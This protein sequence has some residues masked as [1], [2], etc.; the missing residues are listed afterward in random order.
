METLMYTKKDRHDAYIRKRFL[1]FIT[2]KNDTRREGYYEDKQKM[3]P[4]CLCHK[5]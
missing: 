4:I 2:N 3:I 1:I 5:M